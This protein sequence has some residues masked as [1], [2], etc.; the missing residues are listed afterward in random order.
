MKPNY[1][2][3]KATNNMLEKMETKNTELS[4]TLSVGILGYWL[5]V[6]VNTETGVVWMRRD[7]VGRAL[8]PL[9]AAECHR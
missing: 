1:N 3:L 9:P 4:E 8:P 6:Y 2:E 5:R 7:A